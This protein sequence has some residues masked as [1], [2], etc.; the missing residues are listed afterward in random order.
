MST[1]R[2]M[3]CATVACS[4]LATL[5]CLAGQTSSLA[6][7]FSLG[8]NPNQS[9]S[10]GLKAAPTSGLMLLSTPVTLVAGVSGWGTPGTFPF[11][12][13]NFS[14]AT[15]KDGS[16]AYPPLTVAL[17]PGGNCSYV[18]ARWTAPAAGRYDV[19]ASFADLPPNGLPATVDV[20]VV[21]DGVSVFFSSLNGARFETSFSTSGLSLGAGSTVE[22]IVGCG[23]NGNYNYDHTA[24]TA[25]VSSVSYPCVGDIDRNGF[26]D[27]V[28]L[29]IVLTTWGTSGSQYPGADIDGDGVVDGS[30]LGAV[31]AAWGACPT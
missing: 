5:P 25:T 24:V 7:D 28:D 3:H 30:D 6:S 9:W 14:K 18:S 1:I 8:A 10:Y 16:T 19:F 4:T 22:F 29:A 21:V 2:L 12:V 11:V 17:H 13:K 20:Y 15:L 31:L 26:V 23:Q 27:S